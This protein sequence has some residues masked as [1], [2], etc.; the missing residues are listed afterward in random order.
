MNFRK[1]TPTT[2]VLL[3]FVAIQC[4]SRLAAQQQPA[5]EQDH[6]V[7]VKFTT[8]INFDGTNGGNPAGPLIQGPDRNLYGTTFDGGSNTNSNCPGITCGTFFKMSLRGELTTLYNFCSRTNCADGAAP[9]GPLVLGNDGSFYGITEVGGANGAGTVFKITP[10]GTLTTIYN[11]CSQPNCAD[12]AYTFFPEAGTFVQATDGNFYGTNDGGG[13][14]F[15]G[16]AF[17]LTPHGVL[18]TLHSFCSQTNC[19]D[20]EFPTGLIQARDG[21]FYGTALFGG[22]NGDGTVFRITP[23]GTLT[24]VYNFCSQTN[25]TDGAVPNNPLI[26]AR[27]GDLYGTAS[28]GGSSPNPNGTVFKINAQGVLTTLYNFCSL[29]DCA[30]GASPSSSLIQ[31]ADGKF[32]G[33][34]GGLNSGSVTNGI[35]A[36]RLTRKGKLTTL[37]TFDQQFQGPEALVQATN[38]IFY[39]V[40]A[41]GGQ[42]NSCAGLFC[43]TI[44]E[45]AVC[46]HE[47][48]Q[49]EFCEDQA[50]LKRPASEGLID[51]P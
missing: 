12:G 42:Y 28:A 6:Q 40:T 16:T 19:A 18:T 30:D 36:F 38:G 26:Q 5:D 37:H 24:T 43:G 3:L 46:G 22:T 31:A 25:C 35:T 8:L 49:D 21:N 11:W 23:G 2:L 33:S 4:S 14:N 10:A 32:Y 29:P 45:L 51:R 17:R 9:A 7:T 48:Q 47:D 34:T 20:G 27:N 1:L 39:G 13:N 41:E 50:A 15:S 44:F